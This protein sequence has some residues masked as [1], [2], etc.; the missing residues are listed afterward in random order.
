MR[1]NSDAPLSKE[2]QFAANLAMAHRKETEAFKKTFAQDT[3]LK[4][5]CIEKGIEAATGT[6]AMLGDDDE[7]QYCSDTLA[8][9]FYRFLIENQ[10]LTEKDP[11]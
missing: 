10:F 11:A 7:R 5:W 8:R 3:Q 9:L 1:P 6:V 4:M 2:D